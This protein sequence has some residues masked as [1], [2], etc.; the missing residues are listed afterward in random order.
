M[1][2]VYRLFCILASCIVPNLLYPSSINILLKPAPIYIVESVKSKLATEGVIQKKIGQLGT[3][4]PVKVGK[5]LLKNGFEKFL[6]KLSGFIALYGGYVDYSDVD[7][8]ITFP[9][10]HK[11]PK[12]RLVITP[13]IKL[14]NLYGNTIA[15]EALP[16]KTI[17]KSY[18]IERKMDKQKI[19]FWQVTES[20]V[21]KHDRINPTS[22]VILTKPKNLVVTLG[23]FLAT[24]D[25]NLTI[26]GIYVVGNIDQEKIL[27]NFLD[28][29]RY[30][31]Q[32]NVAEKVVSDKKTQRLI[33]NL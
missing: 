6:P 9:L 16:E 4:S 29:R 13:D 12:V 24:S 3:R 17:A 20:K 32:I 22:V 15:Y 8:T 31:E 25:A 26:P 19:L 2:S 1:N 27:L 30:F 10:L 7:G 23:D 21:K 5:N 18:T 14:V 11:K 28:I 33:K